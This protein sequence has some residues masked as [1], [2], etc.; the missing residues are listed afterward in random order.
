MNPNMNPETNENIK[1]KRKRAKSSRLLLA[2][3]AVLLIAV[4]A[5]GALFAKSVL[6]DVRTVKAD[7]RDVVSALR[8]EPERALEATEKLEQDAAALDRLLELPLFDLAAKLPV[9]RDEI[10]AAR[11]LSALLNESTESLLKPG[12]LLLQDY[13]LS[14]LRSGSSGF[15]LKA[16]GAIIEFAS[17][18]S[19]DLSRLAESIESINAMPFGKLEDRYPDLKDQLKLVGSASSFAAEATES[20]L[21]P[22]LDFVTAHPFSTL[23]TEDGGMDLALIND[24]IGYFEES[25]PQ[26]ENLIDRVENFDLGPYNEVDAAEQARDMLEKAMRYYRKAQKLLPVVKAFLGNGEERMYLFAAQNSSEIRASGGFPGAM[27]LVR[28]K[29]GEIIVEDFR[30]VTGMINFYGSWRTAI[31]YQEALLFSDWFYAPR[32]ADFCPDYERVAPIWAVAYEE[33]QG[34]HVDGVISATPS[35]IQRL[36]GVIGDV[37]LADGSVLT[38]DNATRV[39]EYDLYYKYMSATDNTSVGNDITNALF[40]EAAKTVISRITGGIG[41]KDVLKYLSVVEDSA[42]DRTLMLWFADEEEQEAVRAAGLDA[43]LDRDPA[44]PHAGIY[45]SLNNPSRLGWFLD[46]EPE[47]TEIERHEDGSR[48]YAL[49]VKLTNTMTQEEL[50]LASSYIAGYPRG[51]FKGLIHLFAPAGGSVSDVTSDGGLYFAYDEYH[52]LPLAY[53]KNI[54]INPG[55]SI[56]INYTVTTAPGEQ[57]DLGISMTPTLTAYR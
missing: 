31:S 14:E 41:E 25:G 9:T 26:M 44:E 29:N 54:Y 13:P 1:K 8:E 21:K 32:D 42:E 50:S 36:V 30:P 46:M 23:K 5:V 28:V 49:S 19:G 16:I 53:A 35:I 22:S 20:F 39:L 51:V 57:E 27:G 40:S 3:C 43:G 7:L 18:K 6:S 12:V 24:Y 4:L 37:E 11:A 45:I 52:G 17:E 33:E 47:I 2:V 48:V 10:A 55:E 34:E 38:G 56:T 15:N